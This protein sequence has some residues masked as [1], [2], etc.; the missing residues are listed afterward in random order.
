MLGSAQKAWLENIL[1]TTTSKALVIFSSS[2]WLHPTGTDTWASFADERDELVDM[3]T[4]YSWLDRM[5]MVYADRHGVGITGGATNHWGGFPVMQAASRDATPSSPSNPNLFDVLTDT[6]GRNQYG[7]ITVNDG[8]SVIGITLTAWNGTTALGSYTHSI[9]FPT[10][11]LVLPDVTHLIGGSVDVV[12]EVKVLETFQ[13]G[14]EPI[15]TELDLI[16]GEVVIDGTRDVRSTATVRVNGT[17]GQDGDSAFPRGLD[18]LL[19]PFGNE[20]FIRYGFDLGADGILWVPLGYFRISET[21]QDDAPLNPIE[22]PCEDRMATIIDS[23]LIDPRAYDPPMTVGDVFDDLI[24]DVYPEATIQFDDAT[25]DIPLVRQVVA[26]KDRYKPLRELADSFG[27]LFYWDTDGICRIETPPDPNE[28]VWNLRSGRKGSL[29]NAKRA[30]KRQGIYNAV[31]VE[32]E[33]ADDRV[34]VRAVV[35]DDD[36]NSPTR[37]GGPIGKIPLRLETPLVTTQVQALDAAASLLQR[38]IGAPYNVDFD[39]I[40]NPALR[41]FEAIRITYNDGNRDVHLI[42]SVTIP[43][44]EDSA[45]SAQTREKAIL[46]TGSV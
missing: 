2:Q 40:V 46:I 9:V 14:D 6:P 30:F 17:Q 24:L 1:A 12:F 33:G 35:F 16:D 25:G 23:E 29:V 8:G 20:I 31:I 36:P 18:R 44:D 43:L 26:E 42:D 19:A 28:I 5:V 27:K 38:S 21:G 39:A 10:P 11:P 15:G 37:Y 13:T 32:G 22:L 45:M 34:P 41:P 3:F 7:T 4:Q